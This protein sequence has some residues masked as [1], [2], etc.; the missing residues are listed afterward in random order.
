MPTWRYVINKY[1][2]P[3]ISGYMKKKAVIAC[4]AVAV[5]VTALMAGQKSADAVPKETIKVGFIGPLTGGPSLWGIG[6]KN[7]VELAAEE[8]N[9]NGG[10]GGRELQVIY[11]DGKCSS[12]GA[13]EAAN[14]LIN[15]DGVKF[16]LG[17]HCSP[18]TAAIVPVIDKSKV[19]LLAGITSA[20]NAVDGS[21]YAFRTSPTTIEMAEKISEIAIKKYKKLSI[22]TEQSE[23]AKSVSLDIRK[24]FEAVRGVI[25]SEEMYDSTET[26]FRTHILKMTEK[27][28]DAIFI[29]PQNPNAAVIILKQMKEEGV[30]MPIFGNPILV[31]TSVYEKSGGGLDENTFSV[32]PFTD[33]N[34]KE[35]SELIEKYKSRYQSGVPYNLFYVSASYDA[36]Y[37]LKG[38]IEKCGDNTDCVRDYFNGLEYSG[39]SAKYRFKENGDPYF[40][41]WAGIRIVNGTEAIEPL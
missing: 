20:D 38:A 8:I 14:K 5:V 23:F 7:M 1:I 11:E 41:S 36:T 21:E 27:N 34:S 39:V 25:L 13:I 30:K 24:S 26:D 6:A 40:D 33:K 16:I 32:I 2:E 18:E 4:I 22:L 9:A 28:P 35:A 19:F 12:K 31:T 17:G 29:S 10:I 37:M 15:V 3:L